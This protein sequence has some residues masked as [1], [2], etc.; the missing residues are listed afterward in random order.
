MLR[1]W[2]VKLLDPISIEQYYAPVP[3]VDRGLSGHLGAGVPLQVQAV[4][5]TL[6]KIKEKDSAL[7]TSVLLS[8]IATV[9]EIF[10]FFKYF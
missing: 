2:R 10:T 9:F 3:Q 4:P 6:S 5:R 7:Y 8:T 1:L